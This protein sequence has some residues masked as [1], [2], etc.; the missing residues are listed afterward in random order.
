MTPWGSWSRKSLSSMLQTPATAWV[1]S[2]LLFE[3]GGS[4]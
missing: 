4:A 2:P 1:G 3:S